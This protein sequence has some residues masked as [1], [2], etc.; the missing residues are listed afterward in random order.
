MPRWDYHEI[1]YSRIDVDRIKGN[2][3]LFR[4]LTI[5]SYIEITSGIY[6]ENLSSY[7]RGDEPLVSWLQGTWEVE[8]VQHGEAL[9]RYVET[10][11]P[12][13]DWEGGYERFRERYLPLCTTD[14]FQ[15]TKAREM[16]ARMVVET[17]TST[18]YKA[19]SQYA[20]DL[21][22][23]VLEELAR[24][25]SRDEVHHFKAFNE[26]FTRYNA[27]E[28][29]SKKVIIKV[30]YSRLRDASD[31]DV[32]IAHRSLQPD[33]DFEVFRKEIKA[34]AKRYYPYD[35]AVRM[36]MRPLSLNHY[37]EHSTAVTVHK[38]LRVMG[39]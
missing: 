30:L 36:L 7:Y 19:L 12:E 31:E 4:I 14:A 20:A 3:F 15:P 26:A 18:Y 9:R 5:A 29:N 16:L 22:E 11:W 39:I 17:G 32:E 23:P 25:I 34:F 21:D 28:K 8:E 10:V 6:E 33:E 24:N 2:R 1:D 27:D 13:F 38:A 37:I 35:M